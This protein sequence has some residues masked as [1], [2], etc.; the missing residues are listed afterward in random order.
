M[1][2][3]T[4][5]LKPSKAEASALSKLFPSTPPLPKVP[6]GFDPSRDLVCAAQKKK[7]KAV[8]VKPSSLNLALHVGT[9]AIPRGKHR[10]KLLESNRIQKVEFT[11]YMSAQIVKNKIVAAFSSQENFCGAYTL[12]SQSQDGRLT[13]AENQYPTGQQFVNNALKHRGNVYLC[14]KNSK[15]V[16]ITCVCVCVCV[17]VCGRRVLEMLVP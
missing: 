10:K 4:K 7:K 13:L 16:R 1:S 12:L 5:V 3:V 8:R 14:Y 2:T 15:E 11:R 6:S 9:T 17:C